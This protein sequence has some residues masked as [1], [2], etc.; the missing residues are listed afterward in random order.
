MIETTLRDNTKVVIT[1]HG[2]NRTVWLGNLPISA[3]GEK[4]NG[5]DLNK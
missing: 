3:P 1:E 4:Q 2:I 5:R